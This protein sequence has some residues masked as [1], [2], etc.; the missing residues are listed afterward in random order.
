M[1]R[2]TKGLGDK[3]YRGYK[4]TSSLKFTSR[5]C[6]T[7]LVK[8]LTWV[9][10]C[11]YNG[12]RME[13]KII[14]HQKQVN[15]SV[16]GQADSLDDLV[17]ELEKLWKEL[18]KEIEQDTQAKPNVKVK[19][20]KEAQSINYT[21][22]YKKGHQVSDLLLAFVVGAVFML[23]LVYVLGFDPGVRRMIFGF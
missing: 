2:A 6:I 21:I 4:G 18:A 20:N 15:V 16:K 17:A 8:I 13:D 23:V 3:V 1:Y 12:F 22:E 5:A 10:N 19:S 9:K 7:R 11:G 14:S